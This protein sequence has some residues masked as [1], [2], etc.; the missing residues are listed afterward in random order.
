[1]LISYLMIFISKSKLAYFVF[2]F[3]TFDFLLYL[4]QISDVLILYLKL[5][6]LDYLKISMRK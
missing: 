6:L 5:L 3:Y 2:M 4:L 1:M